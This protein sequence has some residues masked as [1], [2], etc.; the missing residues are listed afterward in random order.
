MNKKSNSASCIFC[1]EPA[2]RQVTDEL[3]YFKTNKS[4]YLCSTCFTSFSAGSVMGQFQLN[5][6]VLSLIMAVD[7]DSSVLSL[8]QKLADYAPASKDKI[9]SH[10]Q[11]VGFTPPFELYE[12]L[13]KKVIGQENAKRESPKGR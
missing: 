1:G 3:E 5:N 2:A 6:K 4:I 11:R 10:S 12:Y 7:D 13:C 9:F 8:K